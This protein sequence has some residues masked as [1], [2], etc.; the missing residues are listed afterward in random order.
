VRN[1]PV[2]CDRLQELRLPS[3]VPGI[4]GIPGGSEPGRS[5]EQ[6]ALRTLPPV[7]QLDLAAV[8]AAIR[9]TQVLPDGKARLRI[10]ELAH[11]KGSHTIVGAAAEVHVST[12]TAYRWQNDFFFLVAITRGL[13]D[14][15]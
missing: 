7:K 11:W 9:K 14:A 10:I 2:L 13:I 5:T 8:Q 6:L 4:D 15:K 12:R 3:L 1:Y